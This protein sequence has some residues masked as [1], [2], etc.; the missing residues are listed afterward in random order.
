MKLYDRINKRIIPES[1]WGSLLFDESLHGL[2]EIY[3]IG[4]LSDG[5]P[6]V[7]DALGNYV[8]LDPQKYEVV[9]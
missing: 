8:V 1:E 4:L 2:T 7:S 6:I 9:V 5:W 3:A